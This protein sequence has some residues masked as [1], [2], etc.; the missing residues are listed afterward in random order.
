MNDVAASVAGWT[1]SQGNHPK[2]ILYAGDR[3]AIIAGEFE[4][5]FQLGVGKDKSMEG[6]QIWQR[7]KLVL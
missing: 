4:S 3:K 6:L 5:G 1:C 2:R 7:R